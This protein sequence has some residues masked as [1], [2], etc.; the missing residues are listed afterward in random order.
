MPSLVRTTPLSGTSTVSLQPP[1]Q[2]RGHR[3]RISSTL[4]SCPESEVDC[5]SPTTK[6]VAPELPLKASY[7]GHPLSTDITPLLTREK[8]EVSNS[9]FSFPSR[10]SL[11][12]R[13][14]WL[15]LTAVLIATFCYILLLRTLH[16]SISSSHS[17]APP[18]N[19]YEVDRAL[20]GYSPCRFLFPT[21]IGEQESKARIHFQQ[22]ATLAIRLNRTVVLPNAGSGRLGACRRFPFSHYYDN[23]TLSFPFVTQAE[24]EQWA[25]LRNPTAQFVTLDRKKRWKRRKLDESAD[26]AKEDCIGGMNL[27]LRTSASVMVP[28]SKNSRTKLKLEDTE[29]LVVDKVSNLDVDV[30]LVRHNVRLPFLSASEG[31]RY[32][33][34]WFEKASKI[35]ESI[36][37]FIAVHWRMETVNSRGLPKC[38]QRLTD[39]LHQLQQ[40][41]NVSTVYLAT[42]YPLE[43]RMHSTTWKQHEV[44][45]DHHEAVRRLRA[46][47]DVTSWMTLRK[48]MLGEEEME[49]AEEDSGLLGILDKNMCSEASL[50]VAGS[51]DCSKS[52]SFT[53]QIS[54]ERKRRKEN[55]KPLL[56]IMTQW[57]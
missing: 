48:E 14:H 20:C 3:R 57:S 16:I 13:F 33:P 6:T 21:R 43:G 50:F 27:R 46:H 11:S 12:R 8:C 26:L 2:P 17:R 23:T 1:T 7:E 5:F 51:P 34:R 56:N 47:V 25:K 30:L 39:L 54:N 52:S 18:E 36:K 53:A 24:F 32:N 10:L 49:Y 29:R 37:P 55:G 44:Q 38:A 41:H 28:D 15:L 9:V 35:A 40:Q 22:L 45:A 4:E 31:L 42:D 19:S